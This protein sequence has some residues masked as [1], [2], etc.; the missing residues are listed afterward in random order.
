M[1]K[2]IYS[3]FYLLAA[4][5]LL[6]WIFVTVKS[7]HSWAGWLLG[8]FFLC[9]AL[10]FRGHKFL[11]GFSYTTM[12][13]AAVT[14]AMYYPNYFKTIGSFNLGAVIV[15]MLQLIMFGMGTELSL[16]DFKGIV[17]MPKGVIVGVVCHYIIMPMIGFGVAHAFNFPPEILL[18]RWIDT[19]GD[20]IPVKP[21]II[22]A[23][24]Y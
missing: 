4:V 12:I 3:V 14:L 2:S 23:L 18:V 6:A 11:K 24:Y 1:R 17:Q 22:E 15:P 8:G 10:A 13:F 20:M 9:I 5:L 21:W 16:K 7:M 19:Y